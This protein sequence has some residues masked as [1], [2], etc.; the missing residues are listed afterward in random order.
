MACASKSDFIH[1]CFP[2]VRFLY[3]DTSESSEN[4][5]TREIGEPGEDEATGRD[6]AIWHMQYA[7]H[8]R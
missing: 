8:I 7:G 5:R 4:Q 6:E 3:S 1:K 2:P